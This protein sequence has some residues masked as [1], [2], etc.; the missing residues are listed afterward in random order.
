VTNAELIMNFVKGIN[1]ILADEMVD[2]SF[3]YLSKFQC[4]LIVAQFIGFGEN[5]SI[6]I[7]DGTSRRS[8]FSNFKFYYYY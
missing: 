4:I 1:G 7:I 5:S 8:K 2:I 6:Y 3:R